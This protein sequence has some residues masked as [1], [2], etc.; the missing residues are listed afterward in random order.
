MVAHLKH[1]SASCFLITDLSDPLHFSSLKLSVLLLSG[2]NFWTFP[3]WLGGK[4]STCQCR[5]C[6]FNPWVGKI[7][8]RRKRQPTP[9]F[10]LGKSHR[11][12][13][14][15]GYSPWGSQKSWMQLSNWTILIL[16]TCMLMSVKTSSYIDSFIIIYLFL[17]FVF[18]F[19]L[20]YL[21]IATPTCH[22][23][24]H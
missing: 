2:K 5:R 9:V 21:V 16:G 6:G 4:E 15:V 22:F 1:H 10:L 18:K 23:C 12:R 13:S 24:L 7:P 8:W 19:I 3:K 14:L 11:Q 17:A 20:S